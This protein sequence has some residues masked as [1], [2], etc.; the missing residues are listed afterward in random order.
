MQA[1]INAFLHLQLF[2]ARFFCLSRLDGFWRSEVHR[3]GLRYF[4]SHSCEAASAFHV[5]YVVRCLAP[6][7][8]KKRSS[9]QLLIIFCHAHELVCMKGEE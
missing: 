3:F 1:L 7:E 6:M 4:S 2:R 9:L 5:V 8:L